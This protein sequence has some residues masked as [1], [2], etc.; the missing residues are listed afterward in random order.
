MRCSVCEL[1]TSRL[2]VRTHY[3]LEYPRVRE[4]FIGHAFPAALSP[5]PAKASILRGACPTDRSALRPCRKLWQPSSCVR[6]WRRPS[7][8]PFLGFFQKGAFDA[9]SGV[10]CAIR[11]AECDGPCVRKRAPSSAPHPHAISFVEASSTQVPLSAE[12]GR[13]TARQASGQRRH[14]GAIDRGSFSG[15]CFWALSGHGQAARDPGAAFAPPHLAAITREP[16]CPNRTLHD[17][18]PK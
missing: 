11:W 12:N 10:D 8:H 3:P 17:T 5:V 7:Q 6:C 1:V 18:D 13:R 2:R 16:E 9:L 15:C 14:G 4:L